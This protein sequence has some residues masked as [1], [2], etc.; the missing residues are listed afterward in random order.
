M[1]G[2]SLGYARDDRP[3]P[4]VWTELALGNLLAGGKQALVEGVELAE[5]LVNSW[6]LPLLPAEVCVTDDAVPVDD[7]ESGALAERDHRAL[8][9]VE[10]EDGAV[11]VGEAG[12]G[13]LV[14]LEIGAGVLKIVRC[15][16]DDRGA[17]L[18]E[19]VDSV[20]QLREMLAAERSAEAAEEDEDDRV[21]T[22]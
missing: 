12:E 4:G 17:A 6:D 3:L 7:E 13:Q 2:R 5:G 15:D 9:V 10:S 18:S 16:G 19:F 14:L 8:D 11:G 1:G 21:A 20:P 22:H